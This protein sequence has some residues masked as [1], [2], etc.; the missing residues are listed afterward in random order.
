MVV[1]AAAVSA[2]GSSSG[3]DAGAAFGTAGD[4]GDGNAAAGKKGGFVFFVV[5]V[6]ARLLAWVSKSSFGMIGP[7]FALGLVLVGWAC[8]VGLSRVALGKHFASDVA[9]GMALGL[10]VAW[11]P[12]PAVEP[13]VRNEHTEEKKHTENT[14][15]KI[16]QNLVSPLGHE[17]I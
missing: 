10:A 13:Q 7:E 16:K 5:D 9:C 2:A 12:Y 4:D 6:L 17:L 1:E 8:G 15:T 3:V 11:S 14:I